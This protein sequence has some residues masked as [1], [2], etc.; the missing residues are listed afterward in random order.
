[1]RNISIFEPTNIFVTNSSPW[2]SSKRK[3]FLLNKAQ[4]KLYSSDIR[5]NEY[6]KNGYRYTVLLFNT[7]VKTSLQDFSPRTL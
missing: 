6:S 7:E 3:S 1:M 2:H 5:W 4:K